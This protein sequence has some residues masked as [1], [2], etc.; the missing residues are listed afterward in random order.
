[1]TLP[2]DEPALR[3]AQ[4]YAVTELDSKKQTGI[5]LSL[6]NQA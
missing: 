3:Q 5:V 6:S 2:Y 1:M 4:G